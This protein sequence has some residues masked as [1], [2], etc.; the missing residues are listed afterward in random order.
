MSRKCK[1]NWEEIQRY[2]DEGNSMRDITKNFGVSG[3][4]IWKAVKGERLKTR[5]NRDGVILRIKKYGAPKHSEE[6]KKKISEHRIKWLTE[7]PDK[8]PYLINHSS[9]KSFPEEVFEN[10]LKA[11]NITGWIYRYRHGIYEYDFAFPELKIDVEVDGGTHKTEKVKKIDE[12]RDI[13]S[14][15]AGWKVLRFDSE[16][17]KK[18]VV[19][20]ID[21]LKIFLEPTS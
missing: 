17:V 14:N 6:T 8:V 5:C 20:C 21:K 12:R 15:Q 7:H 18:D 4:S 13:F 2:Y 19:S 9:K 10:A 3:S 16:K 11:F 1:Y